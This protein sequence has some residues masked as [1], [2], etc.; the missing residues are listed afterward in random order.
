MVSENGDEF[1]MN[2][3]DIE[4]SWA[5]DVEIDLRNLD[6]E[7]N[8]SVKLHSK[9]Y[10]LY[11]EASQQLE[12]TKSNRLR[13]LALKTEYYM[14][15]LDKETLD[16]YKWKQYQKAKPLRTDIPNVLERDEDVIQANLKLADQRFLVEFLE[17]II[18]S[19]NSR[20]F[21]VKNVIEFLKFKNG[22]Y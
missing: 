6:Q 13:L 3:E 16:K 4:A 12:K 14:G 22:G 20:Q 7:T 21:H 19:I 18:K 17:S 15:E 8:K 1:E 2:I 11:R 10:K 5:A 9:Y